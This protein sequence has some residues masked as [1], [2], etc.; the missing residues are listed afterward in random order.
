LAYTW[1]CRNY[2]GSGK[3]RSVSEQNKILLAWIIVFI[4]VAVA[5]LAG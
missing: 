2:S 5:M 1:R 3:L 4:I